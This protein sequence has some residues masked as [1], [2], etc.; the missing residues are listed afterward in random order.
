MR[1]DPAIYTD[2]LARKSVDVSKPNALERGARFWLGNAAGV[3][4]A[5][6]M[7]FRMDDKAFRQLWAPLDSW[8][9]VKV[10]A[11]ISVGRTKGNAGEVFNRP[12]RLPWREPI[13]A[14]R[15]HESKWLEVGVSTGVGSK[16]MMRP[17]PTTRGAAS[18]W[19]IMSRG[20]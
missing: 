8:R 4:G 9:P 17:R 10:P 18:N 6:P 19:A 1:R 16:E 14:R 7:S 2:G 15:A 13:V 12:V 5:V 3:Y 20:K 11:E